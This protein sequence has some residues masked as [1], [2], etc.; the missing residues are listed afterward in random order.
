MQALALQ[1]GV[2]VKE[3]LA[4]KDLPLDRLFLGANNSGKNSSKAD[5]KT[6]VKTDAKP[7]SK[8]VPRAELNI[9]M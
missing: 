5:P 6:E 8:W 9:V 3:Y 7:D 1:S 4:S 2:A